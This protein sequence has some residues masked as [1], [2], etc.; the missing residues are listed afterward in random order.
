MSFDP[1][2]QLN[3]L[4]QIFS[5]EAQPIYDSWDQSEG[6]DPI[7][8]EHGGICDTIADTVTQAYFELGYETGVYTSPEI[9]HSYVWVEIGDERYTL[10]IPFQLYEEHTVVGNT[11]QFTKKE[12]IQ[13]EPS[14]ITVKK[15]KQTCNS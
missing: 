8:G 2:E 6:E 14:D 11:S 4:K 5:D 12:N 10:D 3:E 13:F 7:F 9:P 15:Q 1:T